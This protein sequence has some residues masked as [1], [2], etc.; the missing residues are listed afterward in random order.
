MA[1]ASCASVNSVR[2]LA[3][4]GD[5]AY[6]GLLPGIFE[7][8]HQPSTNEVVGFRHDTVDQFPDSRNIMDKADDHSSTPGA[9]IHVAV[10]HYL[11]VDPCNLIVDV[12]NLQRPALA[13]LPLITGS[14]CP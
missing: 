9:G 12:G 8:A 14:R 11:R 7:K 4:S 2:C 3:A 13:N 10:N 5:G 1:H 6:R